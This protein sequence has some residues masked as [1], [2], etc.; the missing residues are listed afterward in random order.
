MGFVRGIGTDRIGYDAS[1]LQFVSVG[2]GQ[3]LGWTQGNT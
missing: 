1:I 2:V 3:G